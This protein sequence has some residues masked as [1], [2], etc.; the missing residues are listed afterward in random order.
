MLT[1]YKMIM[2]YLF[3][4]ILGFFTYRLWFL[5]WNINNKVYHGPRALDIIKN[6]YYDKVSDEYYK[7]NIKTFICPPSI[8]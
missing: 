5:K 3:S 6:V 7:F 2:L 4:V 8:N 1:E